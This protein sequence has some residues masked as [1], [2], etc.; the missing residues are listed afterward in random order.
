MGSTRLSTPKH[1]HHMA[2]SHKVNCA[3]P[4][5]NP[6][7]RMTSCGMLYDTKACVRETS[8]QLM[9]TA[10]SGQAATSPAL[11]SAGLSDWDD[12]PRR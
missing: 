2:R 1:E 4:L 12:T 5:M 3:G 11:T 6:P 8:L 9:S 7:G 10:A